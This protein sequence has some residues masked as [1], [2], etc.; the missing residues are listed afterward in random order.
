MKC[1]A[2]VLNDVILACEYTE[3][4]AIEATKLAASNQNT[5]FEILEKKGCRIEER[6]VEDFKTVITYD[7]LGP[8]IPDG[9][10]FEVV[11]DL[12]LHAPKEFVTGSTLVIDEIRARILEKKVI[13][14]RIEFKYGE[15]ILVPNK[16]GHLMSWPY[17]FCDTQLRILERLT[18]G[19]NTD[20]ETQIGTYEFVTIMST[21][22]D[23]QEME[24]QFCLHCNQGPKICP[25]F[26]PKLKVSDEMTSF[27]CAWQAPCEE[28]W[29]PNT[30][31]R[32]M[33]AD[34][35]DKED[36]GINDDMEWQE[37]LDHQGQ[38]ARIRHMNVVMTSPKEPGNFFNIEFEDGFKIHSVSDYHFDK[39]DD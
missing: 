30:R 39:L 18:Q 11:D 6:D 25:S 22:S 16:F 33:R 19:S 23:I 12:L 8:A 24:W 20:F 2:A 34:E 37:V 4:E 32:F 35:F 15:Q 38:V 1:Y 27:T 7:Q 36:F 10:V 29:S 9:R 3:E 31:F 28:L 17:G 21:P 13:C 26:M 5:S 14:E